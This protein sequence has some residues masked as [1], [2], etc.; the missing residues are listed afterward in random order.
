[1]THHWVNILVKFC[2]RFS[3]QLVLNVKI[4][5]FECIFNFSSFLK[6]MNIISIIR[7]LIQERPV[8]ENMWLCSVNNRFIAKDILYVTEKV[9]V[10]IRAKSQLF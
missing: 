4:V 9:W 7:M 10:I 5:V 2:F 1:L 8:Q 3:G 6:V